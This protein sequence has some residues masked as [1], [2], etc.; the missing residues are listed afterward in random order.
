MPTF[1]G[2]V[3]INNDNDDDD[4]D[5]DDDE[6]DENYDHDHDDYDDA[7]KLTHQLAFFAVT[8]PHL[9]RKSNLS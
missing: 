2:L 6:N 8:K 4:E 1:S 9:S 5:D 7:V 3:I